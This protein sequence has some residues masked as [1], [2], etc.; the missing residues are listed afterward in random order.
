VSSSKEARDAFLHQYSKLRARQE[1]MV[2]SLWRQ[3]LAL[4]KVG[5]YFFVSNFFLIPTLHQSR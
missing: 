5:V 4:K 3:K 2:H 1:E